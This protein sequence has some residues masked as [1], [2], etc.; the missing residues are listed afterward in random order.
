M[1]VLLRRYLVPSSILLCLLCFTGPVGAQQVTVSG[2]VLGPDGQPVPECP[3][4]ASYRD[5]DRQPTTVSATC[6]DAGA[7]SFSL[8]NVGVYVHPIVVAIEPGLELSWAVA[9]EGQEVVLRLDDAPA[10][11]AGLVTDPDATPIPGAKISVCAISRQYENHWSQSKLGLRLGEDSVLRAIADEQGRFAITGLPRGATIALLASAPGAEQVTYAQVPA[12]SSDMH[13]YL[14]PEAIISGRVTREGRPA[15]GVTARVVAGFSRPRTVSAQDGSFTLRGLSPDVYTIGLE[16]APDDL[17]AAAVTNIRVSPGEHYNG[18]ELRLIRGGVITGT[19]TDADTGDPLQGVEI[20]A[21][22]PGY[23]T[24]HTYSNTVCTDQDGVYTLHVPPGEIGMHPRGRSDPPLWGLS[25]PS[26][27]FVQVREG[28]V[29]TDIDF[30]VELRPTVKGRVLRP[31]GQ[32]AAGV[33]VGAITR[34]GYGG[35]PPRRF[36]EP[37]T[38]E[39]GRFKLQVVESRAFGPP[40]GVVARDV[41]QGLAGMVLAEEV[42]ETMEIRLQPGAWLASRVI[43]SEGR[44]VPNITV[45]VKIGDFRQHTRTMPGGRSDQD[46]QLKIG[47]LPPGVDLALELG[48]ALERF[49]VNELEAGNELFNLTPGEERE[50]GPLIVDPRGRTVRGWVSNSEQ[51]AV[52]DALV[53][54]DSVVHPAVT[55]AEGHFEL[56]GLPV[57]GEVKVIAVHPTEPLFAGTVLEP[58]SGTTPVLALGPA[59]EVTGRAVDDQGEPIPTAQVIYKVGIGPPVI[60]VELFRRM[61]E[62]GYGTY[63]Y[64][65]DAGRWR[66]SGFVAGLPYE[67]LLLD[68]HD[69]FGY[70]TLE[71][72]AQPGETIDLGEIVLEKR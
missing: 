48:E 60:S 50:V 43:N 23:P 11:C 69:E 4:L 65:D 21:R 37:R 68:R 38:D 47:P 36:F 63:W 1:K 44:P 45:G 33:E 32:P 67:I 54:G 61:G 7:F 56:S 15:A 27:R 2:R 14:R 49:F 59:A 41:E 66:A 31:D 46:G 8:D 24:G 30:T 70:Q 28:D 10:T 55:N 9:H 40:F 72:T 13:L 53:F 26:S 35:I 34:I 18:V 17:T 22:T 39:A 52:A 6:D 20:Y 71:F 3:V 64:G 5:Q 16:D 62:V 58:D 51:Q 57:R 25:S 12:D 19:F 42:S 29:V